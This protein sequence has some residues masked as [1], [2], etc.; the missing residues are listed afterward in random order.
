[1]EHVSSAFSINFFNYLQAG[2][3]DFLCINQQVQDLFALSELAE[4]HQAWWLRFPNCPE[5]FQCF[6]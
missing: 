1:M 5:I 6:Q 3:V 2:Q 4:N